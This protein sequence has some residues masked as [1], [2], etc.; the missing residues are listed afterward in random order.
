MRFFR[1]SIMFSA[2]VATALAMAATSKI[3]LYIPTSQQQELDARAVSLLVDPVIEAAR[4]AGVASWGKL[5]AGTIEDGKSRLK[6]AVDTAVFAGL[7]AAVADDPT[8][9]TIYDTIMPSYTAGRLKVP[10]SVAAGPDQNRVY[11]MVTVSPRYRY[12]IRGKRDASSSDVEFSFNTHPVPSAIAVATGAL[13]SEDIDFE[14]DGSFVLTVDGTPAD[15][16]RNHIYLPPGTRAM[17]IR[18]TLVHWGRQKPV[19][20]HISRVD[21][22]TALPARTREEITQDA[23]E[24]ISNYIQAMA[25]FENLGL[26]DPTNTIR[27]WVRPVDIGVPGNITSLNRFSVN[28]DEAL[29]FTLDPVGR[30]YLSVQLTDLWLDGLNPLRTTTLNNA[31]VKPNA[32]GSITYVLSPRDPGCCNWLDTDNLKDGYIILRLEQPSQQAAPAEQVVNKIVRD[33]RKVKLGELGSVLP[34]NTPQV[35]P[36][37]RGMQLR[38]RKA[39]YLMR[40]EKAALQN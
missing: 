10:S 40:F 21:G 8:R 28:D 33:V 31:Q 36:R 38:Q 26:K 5:Q 23:T 4:K 6:F 37:E 16:R 19:R 34:E 13:F 27:P 11:R 7:R 20:L 15:G 39:D 3:T 35:D 30:N 18:D 29:V 1:I 9:R 17:L 2:M 22:G 24:I 14:K 25:R 32:D 12:E